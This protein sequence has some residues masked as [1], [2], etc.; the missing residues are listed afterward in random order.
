MLAPAPPAQASI[1]TDLASAFDKGNPFDVF[2]R[3]E[4]RRSL[5]RGA[6]KRDIADNPSTLWIAKDLRYSQIRHV[7]NLRADI[8][9]WRD[10]Q[11]HLGFPIVLADT[12][13]LTFAQNDGEDCGTYDEYCV[14]RSNTTLGGMGP[15]RTGGLL[16][17]FNGSNWKG[18]QRNG[19]PDMPASLFANNIGLLPIR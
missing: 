1:Y 14:D 15:N 6:I 4:Y 16:G 2:F 9:L 7:L 11:L 19:G 12:R 10:L 3:V 18:T 5:K 17:P 13:S 8:S